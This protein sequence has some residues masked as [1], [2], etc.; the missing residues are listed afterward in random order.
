MPPCSSWHSI[1]ITADQSS[2]EGGAIWRTSPSKYSCP[3]LQSRALGVTWQVGLGFSWALVKMLLKPSQRSS[4]TYKVSTLPRLEASTQ[5]L[6]PPYTWY[7]HGRCHTE[8]KQ[9]A[10]K[11]LNVSLCHPVPHHHTQLL[12]HLVGDLVLHLPGPT[13]VKPPGC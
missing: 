7:G 3:Q 8:E 4:S 5:H 13:G 2:W 6:G 10:G 9:Q 1:I 12:V 11:L